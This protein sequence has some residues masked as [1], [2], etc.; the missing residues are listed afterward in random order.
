VEESEILAHIAEAIRTR[1][2]KRNL[3][4][5]KLAAQAK[6]SPSMLWSVLA[7]RNSPNVLWLGRVADALGCR[8]RD[9]LP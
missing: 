4:I 9:L 8:P 6:V 5:E 7:C 1:A 3:S 2:R